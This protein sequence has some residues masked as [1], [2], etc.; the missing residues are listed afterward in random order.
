MSFNTSAK[1]FI[2]ST[3]R[4]NHASDA[5]INDD[6]MTIVNYK[7]IKSMAKFQQI[8]DS[9]PKDIEKPERSIFMRNYLLQHEKDPSN[10]GL[11]DAMFITFMGTCITNSDPNAQLKDS[12]VWSQ[13]RKGSKRSTLY[14]FKDMKSR[15]RYGK[16]MELDLINKAKLQ[17]RVQRCCVMQETMWSFFVN[18]YHHQSG[19]KK[20]LNNCFH[21]D[22]SDEM[23]DS[24]M[25]HGSMGFDGKPLN[26]YDSYIKCIH[27]RIFVLCHAL[28]QHHY[29]IA[30][31]EL[32][33][34]TGDIMM[35]FAVF[36]CMT[37]D[38]SF[39]ISKYMGLAHAICI[40][41][42]ILAWH[43]V[44]IQKKDSYGKLVIP[45]EKYYQ[46]YPNAKSNLRWFK[47]A[48]FGITNEVSERGLPPCLYHERSE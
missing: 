6:I 13:Y 42:N 31:R 2:P 16:K 5:D 26:W 8:G 18:N 46:M 3:T 45:E 34:L 36:D 4:E 41:I 32:W 39:A 23:L 24:I 40:M 44:W 14:L 19:K 20:I 35:L 11:L 43:L 37:I 30:Y 38:S 21:S 28:G 12:C 48:G 17:E 10:M 33:G 22:N 9:C 25:G 7:L 27:A 47:E 29:R 15:C 1:E